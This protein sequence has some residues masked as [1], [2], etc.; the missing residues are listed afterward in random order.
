MSLRQVLFAAVV[1]GLCA[2]VDA[3]PEVTG[4]VS[5][6]A[7]FVLYD[8]SVDASSG[9]APY[10]DAP[11]YP[12]SLPSANHQ[13]VDVWM[14]VVSPS[15]GGNSYWI[16]GRMNAAGAETEPFHVNCT[17]I[18]DSP[19][20]PEA[21][22]FRGSQWLTG[23]YRLPDGRI[24]SIV[25]DEFYGGDFPRGF[26]FHVPS[27]QHCSLGLP[28]GK[29]VNPLGCTYTA[30]TLAVLTPGASS[31][32]LAGDPPDHVIARPSFEFVPNVGKATG[33]FTNT[34]ILKNTDGYYYAE[35]VEVLP[36]GSQKRCPIRTSDLSQPSTWRGLGKSGFTTNIS[37][38]E[39]CEN[40]GIA[41]FPFYLG[42]N[43]Y[44]GKFIM[45]GASAGKIVFALSSDFVH[46]SHPISFGLPMY[47]P[48]SSDWSNNNYPSL[49]DPSSLQKTQDGNAASGAVTGQRAWLVVIQHK[50]PRGTR[51]LAVPVTFSK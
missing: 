14:T 9:C 25:H 50:N 8:A 20:D 36:D 40:A 19:H 30:L 24:Y 32:K 27:S 29:P 38:G 15:N 31:F 4:S 46:W 5:T 11:I 44:F 37:K 43:E 42:Y 7:P 51:A 6:G 28:A 47:D 3:A 12:L 18:L 35:T 34:N 2:Q 1:C 10:L 48:Q 13:D 26:D 39:D 17:P 45:V 41:L 16:K 22:H 33:Y 23:L 49:I 21:R